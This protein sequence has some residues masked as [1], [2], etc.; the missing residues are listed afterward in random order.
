M[1]ESQ[2]E[3]VYLLTVAVPFFLLSTLDMEKNRLKLLTVEIL[4][5][6]I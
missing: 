6:N 2:H 5:L 3:K 1:V 4:L